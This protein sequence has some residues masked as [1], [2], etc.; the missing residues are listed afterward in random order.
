MVSEI[1]R[2]LERFR[3]SL[4]EM[5]MSLLFVL[6]WMLSL[7]AVWIK[8]EKLQISFVNRLIKKEWLMSGLAFL[9][10]LIF[11]KRS[12]I[13]RWLFL[14]PKVIL[15]MADEFLK[16]RI[17]LRRQQLKLYVLLVQSIKTFIITRTFILWMNIFLVMVAI[18]MKRSSIILKVWIL[19]AWWFGIKKMA[20][21][22]RMASLSFEETFRIYL[23]ARVDILRFVFLWMVT[24]I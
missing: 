20:V 5:S 17:L 12:L 11:L 6:G 16:L 22:I 14:N 4:D 13:K 23:L 8:Q 18:H 9:M 10:N 3:K 15:F 1:A 7:R 19:S 21:S 24:A 2:L